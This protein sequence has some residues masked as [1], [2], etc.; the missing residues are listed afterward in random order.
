MGR[1]MIGRQCVKEQGIENSKNRQ[2]R[3]LD[4]TNENVQNERHTNNH[5]STGENERRAP[6]DRHTDNIVRANQAS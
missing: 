4:R 2:G 6:R 5:K 1:Y 3:K